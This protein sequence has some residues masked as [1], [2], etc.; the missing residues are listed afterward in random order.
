MRAASVMGTLSIAAALAGI[1]VLGFAAYVRLAPVDPARWH[2]DIAAPGFTPPD[3]W[4]V[5]CPA[6]G[7]RNDIVSQDRESALVALDAVALSSPRSRRIAGSPAEGRITWESRSALMAYPDYTTAA[8]IPAS[9]GYHL[10]AVARQRFGSNDFGVNAARLGS[11]LQ[12]AFGFN[13]PPDLNWA[14]P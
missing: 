3:G 2:V 1:T 11:W 12:T 13:E 7:S 8:I 6:S 10:C 5:F 9:D 4:T 14:Q